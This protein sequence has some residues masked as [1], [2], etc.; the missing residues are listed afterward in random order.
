M[1]TEEINENQEIPQETVQD[2]EQQKQLQPVVMLQPLASADFYGN[3]EKDELRLILQEIK[4]EALSLDDNGYETALS[5]YMDLIGLR[6]DFSK[7]TPEQVDIVV[8]QRAGNI[9]ELVS[10]YQV[11]M[12]GRNFSALQTK[13]VSLT[14][15]A[16]EDQKH[17]ILALYSDKAIDDEQLALSYH[18][19]A[20]LYEAYESDKNPYKGNDGRKDMVVDY[21]SKAL[22]LTSNVE[23]INTCIRYLPEEYGNKSVLVQ[24]ACERA[25]KTEENNY[26]DAKFEIYSIYG[27]SL[28]KKDLKT[29]L[30]GKQK[31][32]NNTAVIYYQEALRY[33][34]TDSDKLKTLHKILKLQKNVDKEA[35]FETGIELASLKNGREKVLELMTLSYN[36]DGVKRRIL[37]EG[38]ANELIDDTNIPQRERVH[39]WKNIKNSLADLYKDN[40]IKKQHLEEISNKYFKEDKKVSIMPKTIL[41]S[42]GKSYFGSGGR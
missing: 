5:S 34:S 14:N 26:P 31:D 12:V 10:T 42:K 40:D 17:S 7:L 21:M 4:D 36:V 8:D 23:L 11:V 29:S 2:E 39:L 19:I 32:S 18:N 38:A 6:V 41:S 25:L 20:L 35:Y 15:K 16:I 3:F 27:N 9:P 30:T 37:L 24:E 28:L 13:Q 22:R 33:A 1:N